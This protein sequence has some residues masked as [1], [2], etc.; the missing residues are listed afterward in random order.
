MDKR[1]DARRQAGRASGQ[2]GDS[3]DFRDRVERELARDV[4]ELLELTKRVRRWPFALTV[5]IVGVISS[6]LTENL[7]PGPRWTLLV[8]SSGLLVLMYIAVL[9]GHHRWTRR[10][11]LTVTVFITVGLMVST[12][13]LVYSLFHHSENAPTLF[14]NAI[15]LWTTNI[16]VFSTWYWEVDQGGP[17][18]RHSALPGKRDFLFPQGMSDLEGWEDWIPSFSDY[19]FLA[20]NTSTAFSPTDTMVLSRRGKVLMM[21]QSSLSLAIV[22]VLAARAINIIP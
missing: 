3:Q 15:L 18:L 21:I 8:F 20:F 5:V 9:R 16:L 7:T 12:V 1:N 13:S 11:A 14:R 19:M 4:D 17:T 10:L 6:V 22:A 2:K